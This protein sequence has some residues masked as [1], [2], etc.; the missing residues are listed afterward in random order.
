MVL[1]TASCPSGV[2]AQL[3]SLDVALAPLGHD[4]SSIVS[5]A[6]RSLTKASIELP[7]GAARRGATVGRTGPRRVGLT[8]AQPVGHRFRTRMGDSMEIRNEKASTATILKDARFHRAAV[9]ANPKTTHLVARVDAPYAT[10]KAARNATEDTEEL[11]TDAF[12]RLSL[13]DFELDE[14]CR[15]TELDA[16]GAVGKDRKSVE[17]RGCFGTISLSDLVAMRGAKSIRMLHLGI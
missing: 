5:A 2:G 13:A 16:L 11:S 10:L 7:G 6:A 8:E 15:L 3:P 4:W 14:A 9:G 1:S 12:A 17:Y